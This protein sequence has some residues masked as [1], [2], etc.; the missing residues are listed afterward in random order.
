MNDYDT[1]SLM[2]RFNYLEVKRFSEKLLSHLNNFITNHSISMFFRMPLTNSLNRL[3]YP[4]R[5]TLPASS[6]HS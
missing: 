6:F 2:H 1:R 5:F 4:F 3:L